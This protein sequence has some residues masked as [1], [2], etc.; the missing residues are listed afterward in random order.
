MPAFAATPVLAVSIRQPWAELI[1]A[2]RK[3]IEVR[4]WSTVYRGPLWLHIGQKTDRSLETRFGLTQ[5]FHGGF[6]GMVQL[7]AVLPLTPERWVGWRHLHLDSG[8]YRCGLYAWLF[9]EPIR[10]SEPIHSPG[11]LRLFEPNRQ[12]LNR[13]CECLKSNPS[14]VAR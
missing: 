4:S 11:N 9:S 12:V 13:L 1:L 8:E 3:R 5:V 7:K 10:L 6:A 2:G 14:F